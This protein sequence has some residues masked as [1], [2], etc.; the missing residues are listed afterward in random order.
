MHR[1]ST[2]WSQMHDSVIWMQAMAH[3]Q[4]SLA[5]LPEELLLEICILLV[6]PKEEPG[7]LP[8]DLFMLTLV[9]K[10]FHAVLSRPSPLWSCFSMSS[11]L[12]QLFGE[13]QLALDLLTAWIMRR[14]QSI[15]QLFLNNCSTAVANVFI[16]RVG[17]HLM[18]LEWQP[19]PDIAESL[20]KC[21][22]QRIS[23][24]CVPICRPF[25]CPQNFL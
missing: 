11:L 25:S 12:S 1:M 15:E 4:L 13:R 24:L 10:R 19:S 6:E 17:P 22:L 21:R 9:C 5:S 8:P 14:A 3:A 20:Q 23:S 18:G 7:G 16:S 2:V